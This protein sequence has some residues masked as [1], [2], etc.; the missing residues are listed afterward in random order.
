[1]LST[2]VYTPTR[3]VQQGVRDGYDGLGNKVTRNG[4][5]RYGEALTGHKGPGTYTYTSASQEIILEAKLMQNV[6][7]IF[8]V[9]QLY[10]FALGY[11]QSW[12][13]VATIIGACFWNG[14][15][16][17]MVWGFFPVMFGVMCQVA[18]LAEASSLV[19]LAGAQYV[20][21]WLCI[22]RRLAD[23]LPFS[24]GLGCSPRGRVLAFS[25]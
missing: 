14:G 7:R 5:A 23:G 22:H 16:R 15:P 6:K 13:A 20:R 17:A 4:G 9:T 8:S 2:R 1:M 3:D 21:P 24:T 12:E 18:S 10:F 11:M 19:P 25:L